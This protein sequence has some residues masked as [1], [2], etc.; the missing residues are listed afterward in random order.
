V[1]AY[2]AIFSARFRLLLQYRAAAAAGFGT[3]LFWGLIRSMIFAGFYR[4]T[5]VPQPLTYPEVVTYVWLGQATLG[6]LLFGIDNDVR[7]MIRNGTVA[8]ELLRPLDLYSLWYWRAVANRAAPTLL[9]A[10]P[11]LVLAALFFGMALPPSPAA[12]AAW[13][14][15]TLGA[16]LLAAALYTLST[17]TLLWTV[18]GE[19][20]MRL[21]PA[22]I[23]VFSGMLVPLPL[24]PPWAQRVLDFLPFRGLADVPFRLYMGDLP[25]AAALPLFGHQLAWTAALVLT[26]RWLLS[27]GT[28]RLVVQGG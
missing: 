2:A 13:V 27:L 12:A 21:M 7:A 19:G 11:M 17:I 6:L 14:T 1:S 4:S 16:L 26:G 3:Q 5:T 25:A 23:Y 20:V 9:R 18:S 15:T 8:Y 24:F 28:R 22:V 10:V